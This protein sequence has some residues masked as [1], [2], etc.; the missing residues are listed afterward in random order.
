MAC[1]TAMQCALRLMVPGQ[2]VRVGH[3]LS[4]SCSFL[5]CVDTTV[6]CTSQGEF[7]ILLCLWLSYGCSVVR[8]W[9]T[10]YVPLDPSL[11]WRLHHVLTC[12]IC[13][14]A[15]WRKIDVAYVDPLN[16]K[17]T[18]VCFPFYLANMLVLCYVVV[19]WCEFWYYRHIRFE[20]GGDPPKE[21]DI[22]CKACTKCLKMKLVPEFCARCRLISKTRTSIQLFVQVPGPIVGLFCGTAISSVFFFDF[23]F[24]VW[25]ILHIFFVM[26]SLSV[27]LLLRRMT[28]QK[29]V[30]ENGVTGEGY[31]TSQWKY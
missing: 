10:F 4:L 17:T 28:F 24:L 7:C 1:Y 25:D 12:S 11:S 14:V 5:F 27:S 13:S 6:V 8:I 26:N 15:I 3:V 22:G 29:S 18:C 20:V 19:V 30:N 9:K 23:A 21:F 16:D 2:T 31:A